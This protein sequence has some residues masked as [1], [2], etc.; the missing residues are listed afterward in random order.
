MVCNI[1]CKELEVCVEVW[2]SGNCPRGE[3]SVKIITKKAGVA[4]D[5]ARES[6]KNDEMYY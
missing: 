6:E 4:F 2:N 5:N 1:I 3:K